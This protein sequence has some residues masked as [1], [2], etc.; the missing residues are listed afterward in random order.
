[1][2]MQKSVTF[3]KK[4]LKEKKKKKNSKIKNIVKLGIIAIIQENIEV[5]CMAYV[6]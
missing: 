3:A 4:N 1:M 5:L 2:K 6:I